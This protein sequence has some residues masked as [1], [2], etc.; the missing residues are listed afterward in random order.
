MIYQVGPAVPLVH[1]LHACTSNPTQE[2]CLLHK[3]STPTYQVALTLEMRG[4]A[5]VEYSSSAS[6]NELSVSG[7]LELDQRSTF[8]A[9]SS[10]SVYNTPIL[11]PDSEVDPY[12]LVR[13]RF[14]GC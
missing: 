7:R 10:R 3:K 13:V 6:G 2:Q 9:G 8:R 11:F 4:L 1:A 5:Y 14:A 12:R